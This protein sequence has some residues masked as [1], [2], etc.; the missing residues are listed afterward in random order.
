[1]GQ[2][3]QRGAY[4][5]RLAAGKRRM[6]ERED[7]RARERAAREA[8]WTPE[9]RKKRLKARMLMAAVLGLSVSANAD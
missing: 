9:E 4:E 2:A 5:E 6:A 8:A 1:M 3:K 7:E